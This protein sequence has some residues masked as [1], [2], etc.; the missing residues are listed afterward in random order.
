[1]TKCRSIC[2]DRQADAACLLWRTQ[3][4]GKAGL[5]RH[6]EEGWPAI[7]VLDSA[8]TPARSICDTAWCTTNVLE[9][10]GNST[11]KKQQQLC[12]EIDGGQAEVVLF[13]YSLVRIY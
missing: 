4:T 9:I 7:Y 11:H 10:G 13:S 3:S 1:M 2:L 5:D 12:R 8:S 6:L